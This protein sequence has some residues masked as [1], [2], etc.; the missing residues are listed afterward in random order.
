MNIALGTC[1]QIQLC[2]DMRKGGTACTEIQAQ[3][4]PSELVLDLLKFM[5]KL[6]FISMEQELDA[7]MS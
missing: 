3:Y 1:P 7:L 5:A 2:R 4:Q 6:P